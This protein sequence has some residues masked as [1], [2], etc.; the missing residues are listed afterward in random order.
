MIIAK[1]DDSY[2]SKYELTLPENALISFGL[3]HLSEN[4]FAVSDFKAIIVFF[5]EN[6]I[7]VHN[8]LNLFATYNPFSTTSV[9]LT[10]LNTLSLLLIPYSYLRDT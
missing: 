10:H 1:T 6:T 3:C 4:S 5:L 7:F 9:L 2:E 8:I